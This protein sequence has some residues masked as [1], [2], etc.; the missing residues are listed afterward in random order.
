MV[1]VEINVTGWEQTEA[2]LERVMLALSPPSLAG[3]L[4]GP[5]AEWHNKKVEQR[6]ASESDPAGR[7]WTPLAWNTQEYRE[8]SGYGREHPI[9]INTGS[10]FN[11]LSSGGDV[12][13][14]GGSGAQISWPRNGASAE[15]IVKY[16]TNQRGTKSNNF[17]WPV[18]ARPMLGFVPGDVLEVAAL[19]LEWFEFQSGL[20]NG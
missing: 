6:F 19:V 10:L 17:G 5:V 8:K 13:T 1:S 2:S 18:P 12:D 20:I 16:V 7:G 3:M 4:A 15:D 9:L 11:W 14:L